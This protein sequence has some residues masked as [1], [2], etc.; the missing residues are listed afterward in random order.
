MANIP[1]PQQYDDSFMN[2]F[3]RIIDEL[4]SM[5][6]TYEE[7]LQ[8]AQ[9]ILEEARQTN[10]MNK[11]VQQQINTLIAESGTSDAEVLQAR[12]DAD[13]TTHN[14]VKDRID[15]EQLNLERLRDD[16]ELQSAN[17]HA[18]LYIETYVPHDNHAVHPSVLEVSPQQYGA[19]Y[20][21]AFTP[22][23]E[24]RDRFE[25]PSIAVSDDMFSW[26]IPKGLVN[27]VIPNPNHTEGY[28]S[29]PDILDNGSELEMYYRYT[30]RSDAR[31]RIYKTTTTDLINWTS[32]VTVFDFDEFDPTYMSPSVLFES[33]G[34]TVYY[35]DGSGN[36]SLQKSDDGDI[37]QEKNSVN[38]DYGKYDDIVSGIWH[39][40]VRVFDGTYFLTANV[41]LVDNGSAIIILKSY[42]GLNFS[43]PNLVLLPSL[44][45]FDSHRVYRASLVKYGIWY[46]LFYSAFGLDNSNHIG[47]TRASAAMRFTGLNKGDLDF[48]AA[49]KGI[50]TNSIRGYQ[51]RFVTFPDALEV[52]DNIKLVTPGV[53]GVNFAPSK[54]D[55][56]K[57]WNDAKNGYGSLEVEGLFL[58]GR[59]RD[60]NTNESILWVDSA[61]KRFVSGDRS[62][63]YLRTTTLRLLGATGDYE[64]E[65]GTPDII[66]SVVSDYWGFKINFKN[67]K[68]SEKPMVFAMPDDVNGMFND[69]LKCGYFYIRELSY[70][71]ALIGMADAPGG[72]IMTLDDATGGAVRIMIQ[73]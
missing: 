23:S 62:D 41:N 61:S 15:K 57:V 14:T 28:Y 27:P 71:H 2:I 34:Y 58:N 29:D 72:S 52:Y 39:L 43:E 45:G 6:Y 63:F 12:V 47:L 20:V 18:P 51:N 4:N 10:D 9:D 55:T 67:L 31:S 35:R 7:S 22:Y 26:R 17:A 25:N 54:P 19:T 3:K 59:I 56:V 40:E 32:P 65:N 37:W 30:R 49:V 53:A 44:S 33:G 42:D 69:T 5:G 46:Y 68:M 50:V 24:G 38:I 60:P 21:M 36:V 13:G 8:K 11:S 73:Y 1:Y 16:L 64:V 66:D 48:N 70:T